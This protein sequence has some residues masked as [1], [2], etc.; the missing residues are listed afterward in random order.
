MRVR[1]KLNRLSSETQDIHRG[2]PTALPMLMSTVR[3]SRKTLA[4]PSFSSQTLYAMGLHGIVGAGFC[5][6][7]PE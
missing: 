2:A 3:A 6:K 7:G 5:V 1:T 4:G